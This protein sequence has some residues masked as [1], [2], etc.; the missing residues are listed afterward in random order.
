MSLSN[1]LHQARSDDPNERRASVREL[2]ALRESHRL[3]QIEMEEVLAAIGDLPGRHRAELVGLLAR[4]GTA[5]ALVELATLI[6]LEAERA[7]PEFRRPIALGPLRELSE[8][9]ELVIDALLDAVASSGSVADGSILGWWMSHGALDDGGRGTIVDRLRPLIDEGLEKARR[10]LEETPREELVETED[11][12]RMLG[13]LGYWLDLVGRADWQS[14]ESMLV[15]ASSHPDPYLAMWGVVPLLAA[16]RE[17]ARAHIERAAESPDSCVGLLEELDVRGSLGRLPEELRTQPAIARAQMIGWLASPMELGRPPS[18][19]ELLEVRS[20]VDDDGE[21]S[22]LY[23]F[24]FRIEG[25]DPLSERGWLIGVA[26]LYRWAI[27]PTVAQSGHTFSALAAEDSMSIDEHVEAIV[28]VLE[29]WGGS[30][31]GPQNA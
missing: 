8:H 3:S 4:Q 2:A 24:R 18:E 15:V 23:V 10:C 25:T 19:I 16:G 31:P 20:F 21:R 30:R 13:D 14:A 27:Q 22:D 12:R 29:R 5:E 1:A 6:R 9:R 7:D 17:V 11:Y 26:G 28:G